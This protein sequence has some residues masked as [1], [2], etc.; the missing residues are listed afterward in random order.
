MSPEEKKLKAQYTRLAQVLEP[1][2]QEFRRVQ[3]EIQRLEEQKVIIKLA[4]LAELSAMDDLRIP[5]EIL[6]TVC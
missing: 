1:H 6:V 2:H 5:R 4:A 3:A